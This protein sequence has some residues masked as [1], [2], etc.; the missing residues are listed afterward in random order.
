MKH[1]LA[2]MSA[3]ALLVAALA[4]TADQT[5]LDGEFDVSNDDACWV[6]PEWRD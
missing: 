6:A 2:I 4:V 1:A 3:L 5:V